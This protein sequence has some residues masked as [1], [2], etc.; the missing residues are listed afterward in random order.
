MSILKDL[1]AAIKGNVNKAGEAIVDS[2][3]MTILEQEIR[4]A[5]EGIAKATV[6]IRNL[7]AQ[8]IKFDKKS[9][10]LAEDISEYTAKAK[11]ALEQ[12]N[13]DLAR[14][15]AVKIAELTDEKA[16][17][18]AQ[19][20]ELTTQTDRLYKIVKERE[21]SIEKNKI[22]LEKLKTYEQVQKTQTAVAAAMPTNDSGAKRVQ[23]AMDRV[24][25][26]QEEAENRMDA[27]KWLS[28]LEKGSDLDA[29]LADAG[30]TSTGTSA[31][32]ILASLK[33]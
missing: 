10:E 21:A 13:E 19:G 18:D 17:I 16:D 15:V 33:K 32:D 14:K 20:E 8:A 30:L 7:K 26:R 22:E 11:G 6:N 25:T 31:D 1:F 9:A 3:S 27:D 29:E 4:E 28:D 2:Q 12:G 24:K 23:R 5:K